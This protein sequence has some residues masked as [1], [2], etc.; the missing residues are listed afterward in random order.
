GRQRQVDF[1]E[2]EVSL[3]YRESSKKARA[4]QRNA[5]SKNQ[6][7]KPKPKPKTN[8]A[9][10]NAPDVTGAI[11]RVLPDMVHSKQHSG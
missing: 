8:P 10:L 1:Y 5:V 2:F 3:V 9:G 7:P 4:T 6:N 11:L